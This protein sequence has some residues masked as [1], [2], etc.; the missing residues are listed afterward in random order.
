VIIVDGR[1]VAGQIFSAAAMA[2]SPNVLCP[3]QG[4]IRAFLESRITTVRHATQCNR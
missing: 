3:I 4:F 2:M 1:R